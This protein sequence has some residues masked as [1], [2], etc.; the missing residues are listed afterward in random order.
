MDRLLKRLLV[1][2]AFA[3][4]FV[5][6][7]IARAAFI[8]E[9]EAHDQVTRLPAEWAP[10]IP[11]ALPPDECPAPPSAVAPS[12]GADEL[13]DSR[14]PAMCDDRGASVIAPQRILPITDARIEAVPGCGTDASAPVI[15]PGPKHPPLAGAA[16]AL[17]EHASLDALSLL[18]ATWSELAPAFPPV[19]GGPR[20]GFAPG[21]D[22]PPR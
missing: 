3:A 2:F 14:V 19:T 4:A 22:H 6:P 20:C 9:C 21:I 8:P 1:C 16:P 15:G 18:P 11:S 10:A 5:V 13:G 17:V 7:A 12:L